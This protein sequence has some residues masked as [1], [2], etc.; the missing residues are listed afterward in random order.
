MNHQLDGTGK[1]INFNNIMEISNE[2]LFESMLN[3][4]RVI[5]IGNSSFVLSENKGNPIHSFV[6]R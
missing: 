6:L 4:V 5:F 1:L 2:M 3:C